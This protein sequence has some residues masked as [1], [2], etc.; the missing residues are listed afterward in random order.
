MIRAVSSQGRWYIDRKTQFADYQHR[1]ITTIT[2]PYVVYTFGVV[3]NDD[4]A[5]LFRLTAA[6][7]RARHGATVT[8]YDLWRAFGMTNPRNQAAGAIGGTT[9]VANMNRDQRRAR[10][11]KGGNMVF[12]GD[13]EGT[14]GV[15]ASA[16]GRLLARRRWQNR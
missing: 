10:A 6:M 14:D 2:A 1:R 12:H 8:A 13:P 3:G 16:R 4:T 5:E 9:A 15:R 7:L 11:R